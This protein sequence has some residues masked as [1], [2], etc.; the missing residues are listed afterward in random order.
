MDDPDNPKIEETWKRVV[1][2]NGRA[3]FFLTRA[4]MKHLLQQ[5]SPTINIDSCISRNPDPGQSIYAGSKELTESLARC[6]ARELPRK[7]GCTVNTLA[8]DPVATKGFVLAPESVRQDVDS[9]IQST[10]VASHLAKPEE[11]AWV[12]ATLC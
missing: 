12:V 8:S 7:Y 3:T 11:V 5:Y 1:N 10:P 2:I 9:M 6:W 4:S